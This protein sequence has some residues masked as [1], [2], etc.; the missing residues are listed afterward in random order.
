M[1]FAGGLCEFVEGDDAAEDGVEDD[2]GVL[3]G[4][5]VGDPFA[6]VEVEHG[7]AF[8]LVGADAAFDGFVAGV[9]EAVFLEGALADAAVEF[10]TVRAGEVEDVEDVDERFHEAGLFDVAGNAIEHEE[11]DIGLDEVHFGAGVDI[12]LPE[13][14]GEFVG[15]EFAAA[16]VF[17]E[18]LAE[19][20]TGIEGAEDF[21]ADEMDEAG[22]AAED[23]SLGAFAAA[24]GS[25]DQECPEA[26]VF[27]GGHEK[28][29]SCGCPAENLVAGKGPFPKAADRERN[30][31]KSMSEIRRIVLATHNRHKT[32]EF[33]ELLGEGWEIADMSAYPE[34]PVPEETGS[35][36]EENAAIKALAAGGA[37]GPEVLVVA[38]DSG[39]EVDALEGRPGVH[40][41]RYAGP[42]ATDRSN[43]EKVLGELAAAGVRGKARRARFRCVLVVARG[44]ERLG[45]FHGTVEGVLAG[46]GKGE[47][48]F[49][50]DPAFIPA[51]ECRTFGELPAE[52]KHRL[53]HRA[54]AVEQLR[55]WLSGFR[56]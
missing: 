55:S 12:C 52:V 47:G 19:W 3:G 46:E 11:I 22:D 17:D 42:G 40:S 32:G 21:T 43:L 18:F 25:E 50:Y 20:G 6:G 38:D 26:H 7:F 2:G 48:G 34:L 37:L 39:L 35:T 56:G 13:L 14:D 28:A 36:F 4:V 24:G 16:G 51:G 33:R 44:R 41:A 5:D 27:A 10:L 23:G 1:D 30:Q 45:A 9:V 31:K 8:F 53:S 29:G 49:G 54:R 15:D